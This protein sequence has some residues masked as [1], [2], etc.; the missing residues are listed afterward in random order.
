MAA[1]TTMLNARANTRP[2]CS[3]TFTGSKR[4]TRVAMRVVACFALL[5]CD[6]IPS[7]V[8]AQTQV[9]HLPDNSA[10]TLIGWS[11]GTYHELTS[12]KETLHANIQPPL[13]PARNEIASCETTEN[14]LVF[15]IKR[16]G[17]AAKVDNISVHLAWVREHVR[18]ADENGHEIAPLL[19]DWRMN[20]TENPSRLKDDPIALS[21]FPRRGRFVILRVYTGVPAKVLG[22]FRIPNPVRNLLPPF[23]APRFPITLKSGNVGLTVGAVQQARPQN[24]LKIGG[25][26]STGG[27]LPETPV[28]YVAAP[29]ES[30]RRQ[31]NVQLSYRGKPSN[32]W[33]L[34]WLN[35]EMWDASG[36]HYQPFSVGGSDDKLWYLAPN[37]GEPVRVRIAAVQKP[38]EAFAPERVWSIPGVPVPALGAAIQLDKSTNL[39]DVDMNLVGIAGA[40]V[41]QIGNVPLW[42]V[43]DGYAAVVLHVTYGIRPEILLRVNDDHGAPILYSDPSLPPN[44]P[45]QQ[46]PM[47]LPHGGNIGE[48]IGD[49]IY[50]VKLPN[51]CHKIDLAFAHNRVRLFELVL[52]VSLP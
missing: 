36:N 23:T 33:R 7:K 39:D 43:P 20:R 41:K 5:I 11:Y 2:Q 29:G 31:A 35:S 48:H 46:H 6:L 27:D 28:G 18:I 30:G 15:W 44:F 16:S 9:I 13:R 42:S 12:G 1:M 40:G 37:I 52:P 49:F 21:A 47:W 51:K 14:A 50:L 38:D 25:S 4:H 45:A 3:H 8:H 22:E 34:T 26:G 24:F 17:A 32:H 10:I 19:A